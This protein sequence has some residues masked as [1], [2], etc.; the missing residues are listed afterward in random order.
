MERHDDPHDRLTCARCL[1]LW[2]QEFVLPAG[3]AEDVWA[4]GGRPTPPLVVHPRVAARLRKLLDPDA[5]R[6][7]LW[8][9]PA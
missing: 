2:R 8:G 5:D 3:L 6:E 9:E 4:Q 1:E 7:M